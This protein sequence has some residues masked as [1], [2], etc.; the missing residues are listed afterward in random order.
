MKKGIVVLLGV[1]VILSSCGTNAGTGA[2]VGGQ[3]GHVIGSAI[4]G[5]AG[6]WRGSDMGSLIGTVGGVVAGAAIGSAIDNAEQKKYEDYKAS[7]KVMRRE[8]QHDD[9][10]YDPLGRGDDRIDFSPS[11]S[12]LEIRNPKIIETQ[13][14]GV[15]TRGEEYSVVFEIYNTSDHPVFDVRPLVEDITRNKHV[16]ISPNLRVESIAPYQGVRYTATIMA[17]SRLKDGE[18]IIR[19][20]VAQGQHEITS[21]SREFRVPT[22]KKR[23]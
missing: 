12:S 6:G 5:I 19:I 13:H 23:R 8:S 22:A 20:C 15:L 21:Q 18:I 7:R 9:S 14:D 2:Y 4:G 10:G 17:D 16:V 3:F 11:K 1:I